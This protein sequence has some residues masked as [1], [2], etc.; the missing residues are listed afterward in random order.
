MQKKVVVRLE[1]LSLVENGNSIPGR[2][3]DVQISL[4]WDSPNFDQNTSK[5]SFEVELNDGETRTFSGADNEVLYR[6]RAELNTEFAVV[7]ST[8]KTF[9][10]FIGT[11]F[12]N[13]AGS[14]LSGFSSTVVSQLVEKIPDNTVILGAGSVTIDLS[15]LPE[16]GGRK[17]VIIIP[18]KVPMTVE[19]NRQIFDNRTRTW[20]PVKDELLV[21]N[22]INGKLKISFEVFP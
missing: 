15:S 5:R 17:S 7:L 12:N 8:T 1:E 13:I 20:Y 18:L 14:I 19:S 3:S 11:F 4:V 6:L 22:D 9:P 10:K 2:D 21:K 16:P